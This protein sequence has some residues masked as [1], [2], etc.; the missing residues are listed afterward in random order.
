MF[1]QLERLVRK[2]SECTTK[3]TR[4]PAPSPPA[5]KEISDQGTS[6]RAT[7]ISLLI[8]AIALNVQETHPAP[9]SPGHSFPIISTTPTRV[10]QVVARSALSAAAASRRYT[11]QAMGLHLQYALVSTALG[12]ILIRE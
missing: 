6:V 5:D 10:M 9:L 7:I 11:A 8:V 3:L 12:A 1:L 4:F 2:W